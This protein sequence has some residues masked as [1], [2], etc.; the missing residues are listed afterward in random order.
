MMSAYTITVLAPTL[1]HIAGG[2][3]ANSCETSVNAHRDAIVA[4]DALTELGHEVE[5]IS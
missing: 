1:L 3:G 4:A 5:V 2:D